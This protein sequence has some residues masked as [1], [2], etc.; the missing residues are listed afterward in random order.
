MRPLAIVVIDPVGDICS[1]VIEIEEQ[2]LVEKLVAHAAVEALTEG[3]LDGL[4]W[5]DKVPFD[6][7]ACDQAR[8]AFQVNSV[9]LSET[10]KPGLPR[11]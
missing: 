5:G 7:V 11:R 9:P 2:E 8:M 10:I 4:S 6:A 3:V 1:G